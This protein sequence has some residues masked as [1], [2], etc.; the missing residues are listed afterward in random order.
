[1]VCTL[2]RNLAAANRAYSIRWNSS[3]RS[4][5]GVAPLTGLPR[6][7]ALSPPSEASRSITRQ[8]RF[9][10]CGCSSVSPSITSR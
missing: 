3:S 10:N 6:Q 4:C 1:M 8:A 5:Q 7:A 9:R 2:L